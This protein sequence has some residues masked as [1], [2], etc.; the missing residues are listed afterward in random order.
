MGELISII[1]P[2]Y[3]AETRLD[4]CVSSLVK[5]TYKSIEIILVDDGSPDNS[6]KMCDM[7]AEKDD[8][9]K[10][11]HK[12]NGGVSSARNT[13]LTASS[14]K[15]IKFVDSDDYVSE[16]M[17]E[18]LISEMNKTN[19]DVVVCNYIEYLKDKKIEIKNLKTETF[20]D[21]SKATLVLYKN[22]MIQSVCTKL[23]KKEFCSTFENELIIGEDLCFNLSYFSKISK[24]SCVEDMLY[25]YM[26]TNENSITNTE[27][28]DEYYHY[29]KLSNKINSMNISNDVKKYHSMQYLIQLRHCLFKMIDKKNHKSEIKKILNLEEI[30][31][32]L[33]NIQPQGIK[34]KLTILAFK[35]KSLLMFKMMYFFK[36]D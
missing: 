4:R 5:Q 15:Y 23:Y 25:F 33:K 6:P 10:V 27:Y 9:V 24:V 29:T 2:V 7:W 17:C 28:Q 1:V 12:T 11:V 20:D 19:S 26:H 14:G 8:R 34:D 32:S 22:N 21:S 13:G 31:K 30:K 3:K 16:D 35:F 18:K 36:G